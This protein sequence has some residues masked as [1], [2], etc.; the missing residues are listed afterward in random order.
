MKLVEDLF[1]EAPNLPC[2]GII[3]TGGM[4]VIRIAVRRNLDGPAFNCDP[5]TQNLA[6]PRDGSGAFNRH[7]APNFS[8]DLRYHPEMGLQ[9]SPKRVRAAGAPRSRSKERA[10]I[11]RDWAS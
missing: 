6:I 10:V 4:F 1:A 5:S 7:D 11:S 8:K 2:Q 3:S 9:Q